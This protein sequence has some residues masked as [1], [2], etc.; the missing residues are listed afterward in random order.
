MGGDG[1]G[2]LA[3]WMGFGDGAADAIGRIIEAEGELGASRRLVGG[4]KEEP[5]LG[6]VLVERASKA[7][8]LDWMLIGTSTEGDAMEDVLAE[9][10]LKTRCSC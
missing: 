7:D 1:E 3:Y 4:E 6:E 8:I 9:L 5:G 10:P 2:D